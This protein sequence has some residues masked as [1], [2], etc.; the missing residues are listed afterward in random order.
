V[1]ADVK[2]CGMMRG[3]DAREAERLGARY[4]G[5]IFAGGPRLVDESAALAVFE[6]VEDVRRVGVFG[7]QSDERIADL[8]S[9]LSLDVVQL[10]GAASPRRVSELRQ[11]FSGE[12]WPV[13]RL[14]E[15]QLPAEALALFEAGD[16]VVLD[17]KVE[18]QLGGTGVALPWRELAS[19]LEDVRSRGR[20]RLVL[21]GGLR[22]ENVA[23][24]IE[25][26]APDVVDVSSGV[27]RSVGVKDH[28]R[29]RAFSDAV[30]GVRVK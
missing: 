25:L 23:T 6:G 4:V 24:A 27:E 2:F 29:M 15:P 19:T 9:A 10:H 13:L 18:G 5:V 3:D 1:R 17:A 28:A 30:N 7:D 14:A 12:I 8:A 20:A 16:A 21:A 22:P 26:L 11:R